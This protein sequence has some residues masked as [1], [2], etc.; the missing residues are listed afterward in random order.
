MK[1]VFWIVLAVFSGGYSLYGAIDKMAY[2]SMDKDGDGK[3]SHKEFVQFRMTFFVRQDANKDRV[4]E[5]SETHNPGFIKVADTDGDGKASFREAVAQ[6]FRAALR[7]DKDGDG[8]LSFE[9][10]NAE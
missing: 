5:L 6:H 1:A 3:V 4:L 2:A 9:E 10:L 8:F 7:F